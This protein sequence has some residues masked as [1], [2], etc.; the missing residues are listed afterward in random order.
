MISQVLKL[1]IST[2]DEVTIEILTDEFRPSDID[3]D[4]SQHVVDAHLALVHH[5]AD[6]GNRE[7]HV[8]RTRAQRRSDS[9]PLTE[10]GYCRCEAGRL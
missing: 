8:F 5:F 6:V 2:I 1:W 10:L 4:L 3:V 7:R 9:R